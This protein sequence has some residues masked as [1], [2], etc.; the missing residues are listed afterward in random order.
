MSTSPR[1]KLKVVVTG[2]SGDL[3]SLLLP[4]LDADSAVGEVIAIDT[5]TPSQQGG[6][7][8][9][10]RVDLSQPGADKSLEPLLAGADAIFHLAF[11]Y[12]RVHDANFAHELEV[13]G[14]LHVL[15]AVAAAKVKRL[16]LPSM[17]ALYGARPNAAALLREEAPLVRSESRFIHD[18]VEVER[19]LEDFKRAQP[20][21]EV[22]VLRFAPIV[23]PQVNNPVTRLLRTRLVPVLLGFD[24]LWQVIHQDDA[25][26][27]LHQALHARATGTFNVVADDVISLTGLVRASGGAALPL[28][29]P[30]ARAFIQGLEALGVSSVPAALLDYLKYSWVAD[31]RRA[32]EELD[33]TPRLPCEQ[34]AATMKGL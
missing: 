14:S 30:V 9:F 22:V 5:A 10:R 16:V 2:A 7:I 26:S 27:A 18:K 15:S 29:G 11:M 32:R 1:V 17:T 24:P 25:V 3:G 12:G 13:I 19:Q 23:G 33:F 20:E 6:K 21:T 31:G 8:T 4:R 34:A 28:P